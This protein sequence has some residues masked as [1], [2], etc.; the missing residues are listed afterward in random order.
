MSQR[1]RHVGRSLSEIGQAALAVLSAASFVVW[2]V[3]VTTSKTHHPLDF[4]LTIFFALLAATFGL[5]G[6][7]QRRERDTTIGGTH[8][9]FSDGSVVTFGGDVAT[10][11]ASL[12]DWL[13]EQMQ[14]LHGLLSRLNKVLTAEPFDPEKARSVQDHFFEIVKGVDRKLQI[15]APQW[16]DYFNQAPA[17]YPANLT[18]PHADQFRDELVPAIQSTIGQ[19]AHIQAQL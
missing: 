6:L 5:W 7:R 3:S 18:F 8:Y 19:I 13:G 11:D 10:K 12:S 15:E 9:H 17:R 1:E 4:W 14:G 16:V 2:A